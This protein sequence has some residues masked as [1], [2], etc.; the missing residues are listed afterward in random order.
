MLI[1]VCRFVVAATAAALLACGSALLLGVDT[2]YGPA[3]GA[4]RLLG[5]DTSTGDPVAMAAR[6][7]RAL[8]DRPVDGDAFRILGMSAASEGASDRATALYR[9]AVRR[10]PRDWQA[11]AFLMDDEFRR[12]APD[13]GAGHLDAILRVRPDLAKPLMHALSAEFGDARLR[14]AVVDV[15]AR[16]PPWTGGILV[17]L[18]DPGIDPSHAVSFMEDLAARRS[19]TS[20]E[21]STLIDALSRS[22][23]DEAARSAWLATLDPRDRALADSVFDGDFEEEQPI[24][25]EF[26]WSWDAGPGVRM[27][28]EKGAAAS[29]KQFLRLDFSGRAAKPG[30]PAQR[31]LLAPGRYTLSSAF[32]DRTNTSRPFALHIACLAGVELVR[33]E[34]SGGGRLGWAYVSRSFEVPPE[35]TR[36]RLGL[37]LRARSMADTQVVGTLRLDAV[38]V[39]K[40]LQ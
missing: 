34:L 11:H 28:L 32:D 7:R 12:N 20:S 30:A 8:R 24:T 23:K 2:E 36:Q 17:A 25:G 27:T 18:R 13:S 14:R 40:S 39:R 29:G 15:V 16:D 10:D 1:P 37:S 3:L 38:E 33:L 19:L 35:C 26:A 22:G 4:D 6:A 9:I 5:E 31:L 21:L